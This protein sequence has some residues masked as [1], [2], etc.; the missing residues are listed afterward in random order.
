MR[1]PGT[2]WS[3]ACWAGQHAL[4]LP[5]SVAITGCNSL[6]VRQAL[7]AGCEFGRFATRGE[8]RTI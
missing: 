6:P 3:C 8:Q 1:V 7:Q 4:N 2:R 5:A